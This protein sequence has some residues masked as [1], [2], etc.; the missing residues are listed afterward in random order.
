MQ[1]SYINKRLS[2]N[3][4]CTR[5]VHVGIWSFEH[6]LL[7]VFCGFLQLAYY[8]ASYKRVSLSRLRRALRNFVERSRLQCSFHQWP[9]YQSNIFLSVSTDK[10][11][12]IRK[13]LFSLKS[14]ITT[15]PLYHLTS[16]VGDTYNYFL[17]TLTYYWS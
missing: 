8:L 17:L 16:C 4:L 5:P 10:K 2:S 15:V 13:Y 1:V 12:F 9:N 7:S 14:I 3:T 11:V 6:L